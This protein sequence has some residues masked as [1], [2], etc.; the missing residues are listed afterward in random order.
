MK[1]ANFLLGYEYGYNTQSVPVQVIENNGPDDIL[2]EL[3]AGYD[4]T[5]VD[6][7]RVRV[8]SDFL[9]LQ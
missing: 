6:S 1:T 5:L 8:C 2:I 9:D 3:P 7:N 4:A